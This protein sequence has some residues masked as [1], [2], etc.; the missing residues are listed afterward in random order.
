MN[1]EMKA[2][3]FTKYLPIND[4]ESLFEFTENMPEP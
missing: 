1:K 3:R 4:P 2:I